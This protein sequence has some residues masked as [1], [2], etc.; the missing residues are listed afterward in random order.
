MKEIIKALLSWIKLSFLFVSWAVVCSAYIAFVG[1]MW[2]CA[3]TFGQKGNFVIYFPILFAT[4]AAL[5]FF[6]PF[7][8]WVWNFL[9]PKFLL[10]APKEVT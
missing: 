9:A 6:T 7:A 1:G 4:A 3:H 8:S 10:E 2:Y 5:V